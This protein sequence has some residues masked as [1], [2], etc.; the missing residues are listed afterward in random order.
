LLC[1]FLYVI[2]HFWVVDCEE[3]VV[4]EPELFG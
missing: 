4:Y 3:H 2:F 1:F